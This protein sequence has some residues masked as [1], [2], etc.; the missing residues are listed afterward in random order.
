MIPDCLMIDTA[1][2]KRQAPT[3]Q[4]SMGVAIFTNPAAHITAAPCRLDYIKNNLAISDNMTAEAGAPMLFMHAGVD[5]AL[6][7]L[8]TVSTQQGETIAF[9]VVSVRPLRGF[10]G[11]HLEIIGSVRV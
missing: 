7:D 5:V 4:N 11:N 2:V 8:V 10:N 9:K 6:G 3:S 1:T